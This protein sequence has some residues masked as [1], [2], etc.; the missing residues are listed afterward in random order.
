VLKTIPLRSNR[1]GIEPEITAKIAKRGCAVYEVPI[2][3]RGRSYAEGKKIGWKDGV[4]AIYT[5]LKYWLIDDC[6]EECYGRAILQSLSHARRFNKW[7]VDVIGPYLGTRI[8]EIGSGLGNIS[9]HLPK[10]ERLIV[11]DIDATYLELLR[12]AF[13]DNELVNVAK[14]DLNC[15]ADFDALGSE[16]CDTAVCLN[17]LEHIEHDQDALRRLRQLLVPGGRLV[18]LVPQYPGLYGSYDRHVEHYRRYTRQLLDETLRPAILPDQPRR[19]S[20]RS[21]P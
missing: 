13:E 5:I 17:V 8:L 21:R 11:T 14:L 19:T 20:A 9:R 18:L 1:F 7:M 12:E 4:Q 16:V 3:Y 15:Q 10:K 6:F 2:N